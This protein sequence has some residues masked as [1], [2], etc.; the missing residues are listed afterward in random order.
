MAA[1]IIYEGND[2]IIEVRDLQNGVTGNYLDQAAVTVTVKDSAGNNVAGPVWPL[3]MSYVANSNGV[4][5]ATLPASMV[6][7]K[8]ASYTAVVAV[9]GGVGLEAK[10]E[11]EL[12]CQQRSN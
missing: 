5:R 2:T 1:Q 10:W 8:R 3:T 7:A 11:V 12:S 9:N 6:L 4:Y